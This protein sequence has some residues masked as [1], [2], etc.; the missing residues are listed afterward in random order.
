MRIRGRGSGRERR[1]RGC[2]KVK[3][4]RI[5]VVHPEARGDVWEGNQSAISFIFLS[6]EGLGQNDRIFDHPVMVVPRSKVGKT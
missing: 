2:G 5:R 1:E 6:V 4:I 3:T